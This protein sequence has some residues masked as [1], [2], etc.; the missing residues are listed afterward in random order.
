MR[1]V[2][3]TVFLAPIVSLLACN[4]RPSFALKT[5]DS[6]KDRYRSCIVA[7]IMD[8]AESAPD[9]N[10]VQAFANEFVTRLPN[11]DDRAMDAALHDFAGKLACDPAQ[12]D[13]VGGVTRRLVAA[14]SSSPYNARSAQGS[15]KTSVQ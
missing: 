4:S 14:W 6:Q 8:S 2:T 1:V 7:T 3:C 15:L 11:D 12:E 9:V 5:S 13:K 10:A